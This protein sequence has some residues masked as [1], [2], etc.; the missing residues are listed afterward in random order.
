M[1]QIR[2]ASIAM[3]SQTPRTALNPVITVGRADRRLFE[4][5]RGCRRRKRGARAGNAGGGRHSRSGAARRQYAHQFSGGMCQRVM[6]AMALATSPRLLIADEPTTG[7]DVSIAARILDLLRELVRETGAADPADHARPRRR[8]ETCQ[9]VAVMHAG[10]SS[11]RR[12]CARCSTGPAHP[13][14]RALVRSIPR[15]DREIAHGAIPG[16]VP[17][18]LKAPAGCRY[19]RRCPGAPRCRRQ[20]PALSAAAADHAVACFAVE[21]RVP[22]LR[23]TAWS[24]ISRCAASAGC[25]AATAHRRWC[26]PSTACRSPSSRARPSAWW[27]SR[28]A[29]SRPSRAACSARAPDRRHI[30]FDGTELDGLMATSFTRCGAPADG[31]PG[32]DR[33]AQ[34]TPQRC[35]HMVEE[36]L[37]LHT[38]LSPAERRERGARCSRKSGWVRS[39]PAAIR[40][41]CRAAS[42][43]A[44]T[45]PARS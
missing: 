18:L 3:I 17:S 23:L 41:S 4:L 35:A 45:S 38:E 25:T 13:Y 30:R 27:A 22:Q 15:V 16:S 24:S 5:H 10:R 9:R 11:R 21:E 33:V 7:L 6:I 36:P 1:R 28:A 40:T 31:V 8:R 37:K 20:N 19:A 12:R 26:A 39:W 32:P 34:S 44:S 14:T 29:A 2:G 43:S 42:A